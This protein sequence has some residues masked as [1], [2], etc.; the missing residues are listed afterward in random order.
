MATTQHTGWKEWRNIFW[1][2]KGKNIIHDSQENI[3]L[4]NR[5][6]VGHTNIS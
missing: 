2:E 4:F 3:S 5:K 1:N 6:E